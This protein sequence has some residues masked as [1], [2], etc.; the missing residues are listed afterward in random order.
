MADS[1]YYNEHTKT[2]DIPIT[3]LDFKYINECNNIK[4]LENIMKT[5]RSG[6][7]GRYAELE[8]CCEK[9]IRQL[10]PDSFMLTFSLGQ[11]L[12]GNIELAYPLYNQE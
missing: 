9:R 5:L 2:Y 8:S 3:H 11:Y 4:E 12:S 1:L 7:V 6:E 10:N